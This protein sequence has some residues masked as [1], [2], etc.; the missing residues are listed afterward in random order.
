[1]SFYIDTHRSREFLIENTGISRVSVR[2][3]IRP[4]GLDVIDDLIQSG[5]LDPAVRDKFP[6]FTL[7]YSELEWNVSDAISCIPSNP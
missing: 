6:T 7:G 1:M 5:D 3:R 4:M 2:I